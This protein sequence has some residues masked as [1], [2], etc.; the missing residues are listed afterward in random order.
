MFKIKSMYTPIF[1]Y[2][3]YLSHLKVFVLDKFRP[4]FILH[5]VNVYF[6]GVIPVIIL[7]AH[8]TLHQM[9]LSSWYDLHFLTTFHQ[10][11]SPIYKV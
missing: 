11:R 4:I 3:L 9:N 7:V 2:I 10:V 8:G 1:I 5:V 6:F